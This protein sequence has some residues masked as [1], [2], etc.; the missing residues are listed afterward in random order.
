MTEMSQMS[1]M[2]Q[3]K[4][5][6]NDSAKK[7]TVLQAAAAERVF[8]ERLISH[9]PAFFHADRAEEITNKPWETIDET[10]EQ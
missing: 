6:R 9:A 5:D 7:K 3:R 10:A 2:S 4:N 1:V 8:Y